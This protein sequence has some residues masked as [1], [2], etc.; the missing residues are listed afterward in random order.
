MRLFEIVQLSLLSCT[1]IPDTEVLGLKK[2]KMLSLSIRLPVFGLPAVPRPMTPLVG[3]L[4]PAGPMLQNET[5]LL[6]LPTLLVV[7][8]STLPPAGPPTP[9]VDEPST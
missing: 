4:A 2:S 7:L 8:K 1:L 6:L 5:V 3:K 9:E